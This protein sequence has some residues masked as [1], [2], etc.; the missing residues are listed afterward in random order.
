M[1]WLV[2][3]NFNK[4]IKYSS[5]FISS[6][7]N[8]K[9]IMHGRKYGKRSINIFIL[10]KQFSTQKGIV[11]RNL[12]MSVQLENLLTTILKD[13]IVQRTVFHQHWF[14]QELSTKNTNV[15]MMNKN[16]AL[17]MPSIPINQIV[18]S[19]VQLYNMMER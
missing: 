8:G 11:L 9:N 5:I 15:K 16:C 14:H 6:R 12:S 19:L 18:P 2:L 7:K 1:L 17:L 4:H 13:G 10:L 3:S